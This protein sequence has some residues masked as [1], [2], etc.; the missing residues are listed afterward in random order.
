MPYEK[1]SV[2]A[3]VSMFE[4]KNRHIYDTETPSSVISLEDI[5]LNASFEIHFIV[6]LLLMNT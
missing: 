3:T 1:L 2:R 5:Y 6:V 4:H